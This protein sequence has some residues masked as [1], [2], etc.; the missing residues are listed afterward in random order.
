MKRLSLFWL[1]VLLAAV[2][3]GRS[4][5]SPAGA[6]RSEVSIYS[7]K[8]ALFPNGTY[9]ARWDSDIGNN[10][11]ASGQWEMV[12]EEIRLNPKKEEGEM[13]KGYLRVLLVREYQ[14]RK[15]LLRKEDEEYA[16]S[17]FAYLYLQNPP[18]K[19]PS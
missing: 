18:N 17:P 11:T 12:G 6:Y 1:L 19:S 16:D 14:G 9:M 8:V 13:M 3:R 15:A 5:E 4:S 10:G 2:C 7:I